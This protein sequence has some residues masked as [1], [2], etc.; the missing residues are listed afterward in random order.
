MP[1][2]KQAQTRNF[3]DCAGDMFHGLEIARLQVAG[4]RILRG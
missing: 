4:I 3:K 1:Y 2:I